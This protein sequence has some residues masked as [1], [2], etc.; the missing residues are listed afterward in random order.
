MSFRTQAIGIICAACGVAGGYLFSERTQT[1]LQGL[2]APLVEI[3]VCG[4]Q[5]LEGTDYGFEVIEG[6]RT[7]E[8]Q[9][10]NVKNGASKTMRSR[11]LT[12]HAFD[13]MARYKKKLTWENAHY[14]PIAQ[15]FITCSEKLRIPIIWGGEWAMQ[16]M[17]HIE[18]DRKVY[19]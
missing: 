13:F 1:N 14:I 15:A 19:P 18:L 8:K 16:D 11:H 4:A 6:L 5:E 7:V 9:K 3:A 10:V 12:G 2:E 17:V